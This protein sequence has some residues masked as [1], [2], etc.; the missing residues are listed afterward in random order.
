MSPLVAVPQ[1]KLNKANRY[2]R[3][4]RASKRHLS[5]AAISEVSDSFPSDI[6][7][8]AVVSLLGVHIRG[9]LD[10]GASISCLGANGLQ[11]VEQMGLK[12]KKITQSVH[13]ADGTA[14]PVIGYINIPIEFKNKSR[15]ICLYVV[16]SLSQDL[17][18]G[19]DFWKKFG[20]APMMVNEVTASPHVPSPIETASPEIHVLS[21]E[22]QAILDA[23]KNEF[24]ASDKAGLG[25]TTVLK[26]RIDVGDATPIKQRHHFV[27]P[28]IQEALNAEVDSMLERGIIEESKSAW[29]SPVLV[30]KK[31]D[32]KR[33][34][35]LDCRAVN[36]VTVKDAYPMP[37]IDGI[38]ASLHETVYISSIDLKDAF[39]QIEL[40]EQSKDKTAFTVPGRPLY[41]FVRMPFGLCNAPQTMCRLMDKVINSELREY[42]FVYIDDL[43]VVSKC[44]D[45]HITRLKAVAKCLREANLTI[46]VLKS[47]FVMKEIKYLGHLVGHGQI[48]AD[49]G[50]VDAITNFPVP[51]TVR[52]VRRFLGMCGWYRRYIAGFAATASPITDLLGKQHARFVWSDAAQMAFDKLKQSLTSAPVLSHPD[53]TRPFVIQC[54][55][56]NTG[57]G[58]VLYQ[59]DEEGEEHPIAFMSHKLNSAQRNY[60]VTE[61]ECLAAMLSLKKFRGYVEGMTFKIVTDHASLKWLMSQKDLTG[62]LARWSLKLQAFDFTIEHR[63][64]SANLVPDA[65][66][67]VFVDELAATT[68]V[69]CPLDLDDPAFD[70]NE[71]LA[72]KAKIEA[73]QGT[74]PDLQVRDR[75]V[76]IR[77]QRRI[78]DINAENTYWKLW[79]PAS[80]TANTIK[81][82][83]EPPLASHPGIGKTLERLKR[84]FYWP[85]MGRQVVQFVKGC[86]VCK[87][88]KAPNVTLRPPMGSQIKADRPWQ[89]LYIDFLGPYPRSKAGNTTLFIVLD[90]F[91]KFVMLKPMRKASA[92]AVT[93]FLEED[94]FNLFGVPESIWSDNGVQFTS[95]EFRGLVEKFGIKHIRTATHSPQSNASERVNRSILAAI[96]SYVA[97]DQQNW[98]A[99][100]SAIS[101]A[102]RNNVHEATGYTPHYLVFGKHFIQHG[103]CYRLLRELE[104]LPESD[105]DVLPETEFRL[106]VEERVR[107][108]LDAA[109]ERHRS[110]YNSR[111][112]NI[113][114]VPG[115]EIYR[116]NFQLSNFAKGVNAKLGKQW[117]KA[118]IVRQIGNSMYELEDLSGK[119]ISLP[120]HA[121]DL[122]Q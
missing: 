39:W 41:Q 51:N 62:R 105:I 43:L 69:V 7:P 55:A 108:S 67:R 91:T 119:G 46:N 56:S 45:T 54:D 118:R 22:Q 24:L 16:P 26:H 70:D 63:K 72:L 87:E 66:S 60:S 89:R 36:N 40:D 29:S 48:K 47:K 30:I 65:L 15:L 103:S 82:A 53:F 85:K 76:Y 19:M 42:V 104:A 1:P 6:R 33:R 18:L 50:K 44:F 96:R 93:K 32:G 37:I 14:Q 17:Y 38:L 4:V 114:F 115:Q 5:R 52:Q 88:T 98:D 58:G 120:Y 94:I 97:T 9:L 71:Y 95:K 68:P 111:S 10:S 92:T 61:Q 79:V 11:R 31:P 21:A 57:V 121:K 35:C 101:G 13:T 49:P 12:L 64:G 84:Q 117:S 90:Q 99:N 8:H 116:R 2:W 20:L 78:G 74:L 27:S 73:A 75:Q 112:R 107:K 113:T 23:V 28:V 122:K 100:I 77:T 80:M 109:Y 3:G 59:L 34:F 83:H 106:L 102:L 25:K 81:H 86:Q 110:A